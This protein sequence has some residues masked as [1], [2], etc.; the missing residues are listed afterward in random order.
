MPDKHIRGQSAV[1]AG[2]SSNPAARLIVAEG[3]EEVAG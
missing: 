1:Q 2:R 3:L